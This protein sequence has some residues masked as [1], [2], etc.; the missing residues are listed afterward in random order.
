MNSKKLQYY[1]STEI[2]LMFYWNFTFLPD[3][4]W[5]SRKIEPWLKNAHFTST[6]LCLRTVARHKLDNDHMKHRVNFHGS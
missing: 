5:S 4:G 1:G 2:E 3:S 6:C